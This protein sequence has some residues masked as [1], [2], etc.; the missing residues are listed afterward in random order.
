MSEEY[1]GEALMMPKQKVA[2]DVSK[3]NIMSV[4]VPVV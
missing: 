3:K 1:I 2:V 4:N